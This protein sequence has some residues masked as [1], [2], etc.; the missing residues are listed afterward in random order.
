MSETEDS[1]LARIQPHLD[2][3]ARGTLSLTRAEIDAEA[4]P[5]VRK[6]LARVLDAW[7]RTSGGRDLDMVHRDN[8]RFLNSIVENIPDMIFVKDARELRFVR[9]NRAGEE[10]LGFQ[11]ADLL[12]KNDFDFFPAEQAEFFTAKDR[13][14]LAGRQLVTIREEPIDTA[15]H[16]R[17]YLHTKK[18]PIL[19]DDGE[20]IFL[21]GIS[22]DI[23]ER[24][25]DAETL[26]ARTQELARTNAELRI[27]QTELRER[28][29]EM[30]LLLSHFPGAVWTCDRD[31]RIASTAGARAE[32]LGLAPDTVVGRPLLEQFQ[33]IDGVKEAHATALDGGVGTFEFETGARIYEVQVEPLDGRGAL[34]VALDVTERRRLEAQRMEARLQEAQ[35][36]E[37][38]GLLAG[39]IA[40]D[41]N[42]LLVGILGN[43]SLAL[44]KLPMG[45]P[46][47]RSIERIELSADRAA[48]LTRQMLAYSGKGRF[49]IE[50]IDI[51][52]L[53]REMA[54]LLDVSIS[55]KARLVFDFADR[56]AIIDA[57]G[58]QMRQLVMN[59]ITNASDAIGDKPGTITL[60]TRV[61]RCDASYLASTY[62]HQVL[63]EGSYV[64]VEVCDTGQG[65][66]PEVKR[67][68]FDPFFTTKETGH[69]L[70]LAATLGIIRGHGGAVSVYSEAGRGTTMKVLFPEA[71]GPGAITGER[72]VAQ[73]RPNVAPERWRILVVDD[74]ETVRD[75]AASVL[76]DAEFEVVTA[77]DGIDAVETFEGDGG[78]FDL[79]VLDM[80]MPRMGG[81]E[82]FR[83]LRGLD[84]KVR[85]VL[86][87][88]YNEH[89]AS[90]RFGGKG[91]VG[92]L[93]KPYRARDLLDVVAGVL[94]K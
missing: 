12:G 30:E 87:S 3:L 2:A 85:V 37:S 69:G 81:E 46:A 38:L 93:Q 53:V 48:D 23:T 84:P 5:A 45:S 40:H 78:R 34:S 16:G 68:M 4:D 26:A 19:D 79:V 61:V 82:T 89:D 47:R 35:K 57:D 73:T 24:K 18:I 22:A 58:A 44:M 54:N 8:A 31:L 25:L 80:T 17:R 65:M 67:R 88:G 62:L 55:K 90:S 33:G 50:R 83:A 49:R 86:S 6:A 43:A 7:E 52:E 41:F 59:L 92:F 70:G 32:D 11:R 94:G 56:P 66:S 9:F 77:H 42:N 15:K 75:L 1:A 14:V 71:R 64:V 76:R 29:Q 10:L 27:A 91:L 13:E 74:E 39:G 36:L 21:L 20:P 72:P 63:P 60:I 28:E 51:S